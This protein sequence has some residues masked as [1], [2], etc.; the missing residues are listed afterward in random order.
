[1]WHKIWTAARSVLAVLAGLVAIISVAFAIEIP[2][3]ALTLSLF[4]ERFPDQAALDTNVGWMLSQSLYTIPALMLGGYV[5]AWLAP[6][7]GLAHA[8]A[9]AILEELLIVML[10]FDPPHPV[11]PWM[12]VVTLVTTPAAVILGGYLRTWL[13]P[14]TTADL[15]A[16]ADDNKLR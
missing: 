2:M 7:H 1:M 11:P 8:I 5:A 14:A 15:E 3:R 16:Q 9:M 6:M 10:I 12:W 4:P 13:R